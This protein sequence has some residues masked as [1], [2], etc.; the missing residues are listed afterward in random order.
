MVLMLMRGDRL[1]EPEVEPETVQHPH[2]KQL[3]LRLLPGSGEAPPSRSG[4][5]SHPVWG[6]RL[7][8]GHHRY[9]AVPIVWPSRETT[10]L[11]N[12]SLAGYREDDA[13]AAQV[14]TG[15]LTRP[16]REIRPEDVQD[17]WYR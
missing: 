14:V 5:R 15:A 8:S 7:A 4:L 6:Q 9:Q 13:R 11:L 17:A 16:L 12:A 1:E 3:G 2:G 10:R